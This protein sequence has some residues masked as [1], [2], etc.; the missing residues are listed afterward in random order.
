MALE[1]RRARDRE[2]G[3]V[4]RQRHPSRH[5]KN[6]RNRARKWR[7]NNRQRANA[8]ER[9]RSA[10]KRLLNPEK[11]RERKKLWAKNN[12]SLVR[13][14]KQREYK[15][16][17]KQVLKRVRLYIERLKADP[18]RYSEYRLKRTTATAAYR[19]KK[20]NAIGTH[21][22]AQWLARVNFY[23]WRCA[24]CRKTLTLKT[25]T[26]DHVIPVARNGSEFPSNLVPACKRCNQSKGNRKRIPR[27]AVSA[28]TKA[29]S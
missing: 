13:K 29:S 4:Y 20:R 5:R 21:T 19:A 18:V 1:E 8:L 10:Q 15:R 17:R 23:G 16:H 6:S 24:Y 27:L 28:F 9:A 12:P 7:K 25:L 11:I 14:H 3:R 26:K 22:L 2:Y